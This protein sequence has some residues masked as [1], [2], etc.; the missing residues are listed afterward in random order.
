MPGQ[1]APPLI[2]EAFAKN[3]APGF[4]TTPIPVSTADPARAS[5]NLGFPPQTMT[6]IFAGG[7]PPYGQ[8]VNGILNM[9]SAHIAA[10]A[11]GQPPYYNA[12]LSTAMGGYALGAVL[13]M[14]DGSG[15]WINTLSGNTTDPD[16]GSPT[17]WMPLYSR[18]F[19]T[20]ALPSAGVYTL[21]PAEYRKG[22]VV[23]AGTLGGNLQVVVPGG[24]I[25][26]RAWLIVNTTT[27][28]FTVTVKTLAGTGVVVPSGGYGAPTEVYGDG[29][30][31]YPTVAPVNLPIDQAPNPLTIAQRT[32]NGYLFA[33]YFNSNNSLENFTM[34]AVYADAG[35]GY[36]RKISPVNFAAQINLQWLA[37]VIAN[38]QVPQSAVT[39]HA[40]AVLA[41]AALTGTPTAP[42]QGVG[43][44]STAVATTQ[45]VMSQSLGNAQSWAD[46]TGGR[47]L[48]TTYTNGT[49][50]SI[51][52]AFT[53]NCRRSS[54]GGG[55]FTLVCNGVQVGQLH[56][57]GSTDMSAATS[58]TVPP[59]GTYAVTQGGAFNGYVWAELS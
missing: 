13:G 31:V 20:P 53:G 7:T 17:N 55:A 34:A 16:G 21:T 2:V 54:A 40:P 41:N 28:G 35:D 6:E 49:G 24:T 36:H 10:T 27:G 3:A 48:N 47:A 50:R 51:E 4:I 23:L 9:L 39:Q 42:T 58:F 18:G 33:T 57:A 32:N 14:N 15:V 59:G 43:N 46:V 25:G 8:D 1:P 11:A 44:N 52:V 29:T 30:N 19:A 45:F 56:A 22:V 5:F 37:G 12:T 38:A 26:Q